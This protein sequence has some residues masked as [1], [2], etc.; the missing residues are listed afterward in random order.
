MKSIL[1]LS[2]T[3]ILSLG[4]LSTVLAGSYNVNKKKVAISGY[5]PVAY[6]TLK[7][8]TKGN[9]QFSSIYKGATFWFSSKKTS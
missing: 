2:Y 9:K 7:K 4:L 1:I 8:A 5:D 6:F 3:F